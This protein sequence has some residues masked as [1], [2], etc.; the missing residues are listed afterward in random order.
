MKS[1]WT[2][3][4]PNHKSS[5]RKIQKCLLQRNVFLHILAT[6]Y[7]K[8]VTLI[9]K[10]FQFSR[11]KCNFGNFCH[12]NSNEI[13]MLQSKI[14]SMPNTFQTYNCQGLFFWVQKMQ[15]TNSVSANEIKLFFQWSFC[16]AEI[17]QVGLHLNTNLNLEYLLLLFYQGAHTKMCLT[18]L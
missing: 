12:E 9:S 5:F 17:I 7:F 4:I 15:Q 2:P 11:Q 10:R 6:F 16:E 14:N 18:V 1:F 13:K 3:Q 8:N